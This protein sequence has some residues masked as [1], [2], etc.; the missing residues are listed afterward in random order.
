MIKI[1]PYNPNWPQMFEAEARL[2]L[3]VLGANCLAIHHIGSTSIPGMAAKPIIDILPIVKNIVQ[4]DES[5]KAMEKLGYEAK[6]EYGILFRRYFKKNETFNVH[7]FEADDT[8][9]DRYL[10]F[11]D[12]M[13]MHPDDAKAYAQLKREL[14][15]K[16]PN[17]ILKYCSGKDLFV[18]KIDAKDGF[19]GFRI[20]KALTENE[21]DAISRML[22]QKDISTLITD[23]MEHIH[24]VFYKNSEIIGYAQLQFLDEKKALLRKIIIEDSFR[25]DFL[26]RIE[27][28]LHQK[29]INAI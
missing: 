9:V 12:W 3:K 11:R 18:A 4:V 13:R 26:H 7:V 6:G 27:K 1:V 5:N 21:W 29:G 2:I 23:K 15:Q 19:E 14:A 17:D 28:W 20:V 10:K 16:Y 8:E 22:K 25:N 24:L